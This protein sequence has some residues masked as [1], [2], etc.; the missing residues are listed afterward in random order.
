MERELAK[1]LNHQLERGPA[2]LQRR[3]EAMLRGARETRG[4]KQYSDEQR[5]EQLG[6]WSQR[7]CFRWPSREVTCD[8][9]ERE[10]GIWVMHSLVRGS[11]E[12]KDTAFCVVLQAFRR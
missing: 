11:P 7:N 9:A 6:Q 5:L 12:L 10:L 2:E 1:W 4:G 3:L 8:A